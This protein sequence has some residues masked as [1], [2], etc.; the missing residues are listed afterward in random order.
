M[1]TVSLTSLTR[2]IHPQNGIL[3]SPSRKSLAVPN[4]HDKATERQSPVLDDTDA[5]RLLSPVVQD[6]PK[7]PAAKSLPVAILARLIESS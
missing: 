5:N 1:L 4:R 3:L 2:I 6:T 7:P